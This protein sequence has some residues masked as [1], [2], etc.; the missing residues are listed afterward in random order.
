MIRVAIC[1]CGSVGTP[2]ENQKI[3]EDLFLQSVEGANNLD[4]VVFPEY[5]YYSPLDKNESLHVAIDLERPHPFIDSMKRLAKQYKVNLIPGSFA[6]KAENG[7]VCNAVI[8]I[9]R[10]G[11]IIGKYRKIH[12]F[13]AANYK[14]SSYVE[15][16]DKLCI[17]DTDFGKMGV[18]VCY[19]L[20]FT[21]LAR[22]MCLSGADFIVC[23]AEFPC[24]QPLPTRVD[25]WDLLV[26]STALTNVTYVVAA[27]QFGKVHNDH[28]FGRSC[29][30]DPR[31]TVISAAQGRNCVVYG[32]VDLDYQKQTRENLAVWNNRKP[33]VYIL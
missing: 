22:S 6:E 16:G 15:P 25:D 23:P 11:E 20:R 8:T 30:V 17:V 18:M 1:Q 31:G 5:S 28:P 2:E 24:G 13:D 19:D 3:M 33:S 14:E 10:N 4:L 7:K 21:E 12:L 26:R 32:C 27:N 9:D 29:I